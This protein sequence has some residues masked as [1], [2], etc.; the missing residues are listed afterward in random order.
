MEKEEEIH[1]I[2]IKKYKKFNRKLP[3]NLIVKV[4]VVILAIG[5]LYYFKSITSQVEKT[6]DFEINISE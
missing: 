2:D 3:W 5:L 1:N 4:V 6:D